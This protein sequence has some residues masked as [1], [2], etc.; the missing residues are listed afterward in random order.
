M[1]HPVGKYIS[2]DEEHELN[3][4]LKKNGFKESGS[5]RKSLVTLIYAAKSGLDMD[6]GDHLEHVELDEY[7]EQSKSA[8]LDDFE[9]K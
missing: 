1:G 3:Y 4:W 7:F 5:N 8:W 9:K 2:T 6:S